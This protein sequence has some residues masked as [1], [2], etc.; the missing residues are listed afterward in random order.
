MSLGKNK[1]SMHRPCNLKYGIITKLFAVVVYLISTR[2]YPVRRGGVIPTRPLQN[3]IIS[4][5]K[6]RRPYQNPN[7]PLP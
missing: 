7:F 5:M 6:N 4:R 1:L 3:S 2:T